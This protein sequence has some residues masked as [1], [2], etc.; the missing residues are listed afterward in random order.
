MLKEAQFIVIEGGDG[1]GKATQTR[2][3]DQYLRNSTKI[4]VEKISYPVYEDPSAYCVTRILREEGVIDHEGNLRYIKSAAYAMNRAL[5]FFDKYNTRLYDIIKKKGIVV[6]DRYSSSNI[7]HIA[8]ILDS[9]EEVNEC[10]DFIQDLEHEKFKLPKP[11]KVFYLDVP[12]EVSMKNIEKRGNEKDLNENIEHLSKVYER[13]RYVVDKLGWT[14]IDC[15]NAQ[16]NQKS[17]L[18]I[19]LEIMKHVSPMLK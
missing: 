18:E 16:G 1:S 19:H 8:S 10:I 4:P 13:S 17:V 7:L 2:L 15:M 3:L 14:R 5:T 9:I 11:T 6:F 12:P